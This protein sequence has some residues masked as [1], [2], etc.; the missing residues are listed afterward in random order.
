MKKSSVVLLVISAILTLGVFVKPLWFISLEAPQYP[1]GITMY[2]HVNKITGNEENTLDNINILNHYIGMKYIVPESI[3][4]L[5]YFPYIIIGLCITGVLAAFSR[6]KWLAYTWII[7]LTVLCILGIYVFWLWEY[8]NGHNL[9]PNAAIKV[10]GMT[11][12]PPLFGEK[13]LLNFKATSYPHVGGILLGI[14]VLLANAVWF[15]QRKK[16]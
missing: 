5:T 14:S 9:D 3:P 10:E 7:S 1:E 6:K 12:Q 2:L 16:A 15:V 8:D 11:Y 4:E 13:W